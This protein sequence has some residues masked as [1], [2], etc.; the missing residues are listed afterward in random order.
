MKDP[1]PRA[2]WARL[3]GE[4]CGACGFVKSKGG[5]E[6]DKGRKGGHGGG[7][8]GLRATVGISYGTIGTIIRNTSALVTG[9]AKWL[10]GGNDER[11]GA[12]G[13]RC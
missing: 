11:H 8:G 3:S 5:H 10:P 6:L 7:K 13:R 2:S 1:H 12:I 4:G 9:R